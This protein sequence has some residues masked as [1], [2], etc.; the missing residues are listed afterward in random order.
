M[1][2]LCSISTLTVVSN[3]STSCWLTEPRRPLCLWHR[4]ICR[5]REAIWAGNGK[6]FMRVALE[7]C[8]TC[9]HSI[10]FCSSPSFLPPLLFFLLLLCD[11]WSCSWMMERKA[12]TFHCSQ[13]KFNCRQNESQCDV[14]GHGRV[15]GTDRWFLLSAHFLPLI[16]CHFSLEVHVHL[17]SL[18]WEGFHLSEKGA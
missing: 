16:C 1:F 2:S 5:S 7:W 18:V 10:D 8:E 13:L 15:C 9:S 14:R 11:W 6:E 17:M 4:G 3:Q 12:M